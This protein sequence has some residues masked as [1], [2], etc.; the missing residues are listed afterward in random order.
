MARYR[1]RRP[2]KATSPSKLRAI[3]R[4]VDALWV[5][6]VNAGRNVSDKD[7][8]ALALISEAAGDLSHAAGLLGRASN[9]V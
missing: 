6:T 7:S 9:E 2:T 3:K 1:V 4:K 5:E 8:R